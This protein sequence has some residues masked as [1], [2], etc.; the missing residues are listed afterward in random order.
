MTDTW[1]KAID[2]VFKWEGG[3]FDDPNAGETK[4]GISKR[5]YPDLDIATLTP[6]EAKAI[7][8][9]DYWDKLNCDT[10]GYPWDI[11]AFNAGVNCGVARA[12]MWLSETHGWQE[13]LL[14]QIFY[15][16]T[17]AKKEQFKSFLRGWLNRTIDLFMLVRGNA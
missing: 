13:F 5:A 14:M 11:C 4:Y 2:F 16:T 3:Y 9:S 10:L 6:T 1:D 8:K 17:L 12:E 15:Y 7:Y